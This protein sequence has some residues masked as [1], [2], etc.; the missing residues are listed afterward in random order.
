MSPGD[1]HFD[2]PYFYVNPYGVENP[3][4][5]PSLAGGADWAE[6]WLGAVLT[7]DKILAANDPMATTKSFLNDA[8]AMMRS[9]F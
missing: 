8:V 4:E 3:G 1:G 5:L 6:G 7:A 9:W 2:Q